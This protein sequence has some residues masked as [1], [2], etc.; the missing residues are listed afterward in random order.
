[1]TDHPEAAD[2]TALR[3]ISDAEGFIAK[4]CFKTGPP[5]WTGVELEWTVHH[6]D[7]PARPLD[8]S[9][10]RT[11]LGPYRPTTLDPTHTPRPLG[12]GGA[13]TVE[14]GGQVE[15]ST[16]PARSLAVLHRDTTADISALTRRLA[17]QGLVLGASGIDPHRAP[18][19]VLTTP[20]YAAMARSFDRRGPH[21]QIMMR[22]TAGLQVC[23]DAGEAHDLPARWRLL[24]LLG[25]PLLAAFATASRHAG[26]DTGFASAR[27]DAWWQID[28]ARTR[29]AWT[30]DHDGDR[31]DPLWPARRWA[32]YALAAPLLCIRR[33]G[34]H[35]DAPAG[36]TFADWIGGA[37]P[38]PPTHDDLDYHL[39]TLFPPVRPRG[40]LEIRYLDTQPAGEW[41]APAAVLVALLAGP[42]V[43]EEATAL[44]RP[45]ADSWDVAIRCGMKDPLIAAIAR[46]VL[47]LAVRNLHRT[48]LSG[49][50][51]DQ[52]LDIVR[53]R[54]AREGQQP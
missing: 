51:Q 20:R 48:D 53:R 17:E 13:V 43:I 3:S 29:P 38:T 47:D 42:D 40:Y 28:P 14:P 26:R 39:S 6:A 10:L 31:H 12:A 50:V 15:I 46:Q 41:I 27:M 37:L 54:L 44:C 33:D 32:D 52:V 25:P 49:P 34:D 11:A 1:M 8:V 30:R 2:P 35:W 5:R 4:V 23:V 36:V 16:Q 22:C 24:H 7:D 9:A 18:R 19:P 21:G 45:V